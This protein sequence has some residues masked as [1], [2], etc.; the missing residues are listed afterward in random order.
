MLYLNSFSPSFYI[1]LILTLHLHFCCSFLIYVILQNRIIVIKDGPEIDFP[2]IRNPKC[3]IRNPKLFRNSDWLELSKRILR[4]S[5]HLS[6]LERRIM[7]HWIPLI[8][9]NPMIENTYF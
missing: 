1:N 2:K 6:I 4:I 9:T 8:E 7:V 5:R 3:R